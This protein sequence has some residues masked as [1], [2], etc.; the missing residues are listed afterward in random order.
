ME[1]VGEGGGASVEVIGL[2]G[3]AFDGVESGEGGEPVIR[4][5]CPQLAADAVGLELGVSLEFVREFEQERGVGV[6]FA[7]FY[8]VGSVGA[9]PYNLN[10]SEFSDNWGLGLRL[11]LP[12]GPLRLDYGIPIHHD[13]YSSPSG[14]FQFGV[15]W[16]RPF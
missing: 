16:E 8:D 6:R 5:E 14:K 15:G 11:N 1:W 3:E 9:S 13:Q 7:L 4:W 2:M 12:I 10:F